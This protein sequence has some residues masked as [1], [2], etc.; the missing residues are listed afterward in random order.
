[1][2]SSNY[3]YKII[4]CLYTIMI[5]NILIQY[6]F[7]GLV[8]WGCRTHWLHLCCWVSPPPV[9]NKCPGYDIKQ[10]DGEVPVMLELWRMQSAPSLLLLP[11]LLRSSVLAPDMGEIELFEI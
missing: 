6:K 11:G 7:S 3:Y 2:V 4:I 10:S 8:G 9:V 1:M 5:S